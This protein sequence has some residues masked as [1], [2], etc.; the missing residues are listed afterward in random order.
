M[1]SPFVYTYR[2]FPTDDAHNLQKQLVN[3]STQYGVAIN[4]R[5]IGLFDLHTPGESDAT[6]N[7]ERWFPVSNQQTAPLK[8]RDGFRLVV[9]VADGSLSVNHNIT[10][11][12]QVTRLYGA[13]QDGSGNWWPLPYVDVVAANNQINVKV[14]AT[15]IVVTKGAGTPPSINSGV[16]VLEYL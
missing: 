2:D 7:G 10:Q 14:T 1:N 12:N 4:Q 11:I 3:Q 15:Q 13:F 9:Q 8:L 16:V 6:A 5:T